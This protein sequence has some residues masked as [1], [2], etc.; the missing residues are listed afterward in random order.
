MCSSSSPFF[1]FTLSHF[2]K[3]CCKHVIMTEQQILLYCHTIQGSSIS[4][5]ACVCWNKLTAVVLKP[6]IKEIHHISCTVY[7]LIS[8]VSQHM[9]MHTYT[10][11]HHFF[12]LYILFG[13]KATEVHVKN[14]GVTWCALLQSVIVCKY[15]AKIDINHWITPSLMCYSV[16]K[17]G[18]FNRMVRQGLLKR[19]L[20]VN[21]SVMCTVVDLYHRVTW[22][23]PWVM[24]LTFLTVY[25]LLQEEE[26]GCPIDGSE[27]VTPCVDGW[28]PCLCCV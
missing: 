11:K 6:V 2:G 13:I 21:S 19:I 18:W 28:V 5:K 24:H 12:Y 8:A 14:Y 7:C 25:N 22:S 15:I 17:W 20:H 23:E 10:C 3:Y 1:F 4:L 27:E 16:P 9:L 26:V